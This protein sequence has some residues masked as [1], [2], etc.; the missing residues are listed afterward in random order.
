[1]NRIKNIFPDWLIGILLTILILFAFSNEWHPL[2]T[3]E[4]TTYDLRSIFRQKKASAPVVI[5]AIDETSIASIGRWP[6]PRA[7]MAGMIDMLTEYGAKVIGVNVLY[8]EPDRNSGLIEIKALRE[9]I[10]SIPRFQ[11]NQQLMRFYNSLSDAERRLNNDAIL[12]ASIASSK[13]VILPLFFTIGEQSGGTDSDVPE[14]LKKNS[15]E[16]TQNLLYINAAEV[17]APIQEYVSG[18]LALG[19]INLLADRDGTIRREALFINYK[20]RIYPSFAL[21]TVIK[22][23]DLN[24]HDAKIFDGMSLGK[25]TI[26]TDE[27]QRMLIS[28]NGKFNTFPYFSFVDA[29]NNKVPPDA[30]KNKI[31]LVGHTATGIATLAVTPVDNTLPTVEIEANVIENL[32]NNN[33]ISRPG[34]ADLAEFGIIVFFGIFLSFIIPKLKAGVS[35]IISLLLLIAWNSAAIYLFTSQGLWLNMF[36]PTV[37]LALGYTII[38]SKRYLLTEELKERVEA[39]SVETN[40]MLGLSFQGQGMLDLAFEKFRKCP[41]E[42]ESVRELL[43]NLGLDFERKRMFN[44][45][46]AVYEH[47]LKTG[48]FKDIKERIKRLKVA[49]ETMIFGTT[50]SKKE[51]TI[52]VEDSPIKP[53]LGRYEIQKK[54]GR[55]AMGT[56]FLGKDPKINRLVAIK[57]IRFDEIDPAELAEAKKRFFREAESAGT[58]SHPNIVTIYDAGED[59]DVAY[60]AMELLEGKDLTSFASKNNRLPVKEILKIV[61]SVAE[62]LDYAHSKGIVHRDIKPANIMLLK[63]G[64]VKITDFGIARVIASSKTQTGVVL[65]TPSYMSPEQVL[66]KKVDGRSDLFSLGVVFF[67][68]VSSAKPFTGDSIATLMFNIANTQHP[69]VRELAQDIPGCCV[70]LINMMLEKDVDMRYQRGRDIASDISKCMENLS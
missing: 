19:H 54:L 4:Y 34:W 51:A 3:L 44:K 30:F 2:Q 8:T 68:L 35:A 23:L 36:I 61:G 6:W 20:G 27:K 37:F 21:Q 64:D 7:Y 63:T 46:A 65:G 28:Y 39:D 57:T 45:A 59:H 18:A 11:K 67:E 50:S 5:V 49:G 70:P 41:I 17:S 9:E 48:N 13:K 22:Y 53:T 1:M 38:M 12:S 26:P 32:L 15:S 10:E 33:F 31:V 66:G 56:V 40:K 52:L 42:D 60:V 47:I 55:G 58:L 69:Q 14:Y 16:T 29:I 24:V 25:I 62:G 43:Y